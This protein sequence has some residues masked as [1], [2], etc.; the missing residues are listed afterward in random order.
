MRTARIT[1]GLR[2]EQIEQFAGSWAAETPSGHGLE[3]E[4][5][6]TGNRVTVRSKREGIPTNWNPADLQRTFAIALHRVAPG[7]Q[8]DWDG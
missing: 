4:F 8:I 7:A 3:F 6:E 5:D 1:P 2:P